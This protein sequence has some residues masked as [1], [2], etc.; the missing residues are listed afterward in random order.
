MR[1]IDGDMSENMISII[2]PVY[3]SRERLTECLESV[4]QQSYENKEVI[5]VDDCSTDGSLEICREYEKKYAFF[6]VYTKENE[7]VSAARNYGLSRAKG[8]LIQFVDS[9]DMLYPETCKILAE[10]IQRDESDLVICGYYNEKEKRKAVYGEY[11]FSDKSEFMKEFSGLFSQF[12]LHVPWNKLYRRCLIDEAAA[13]FPTDLSKGED[14]LFNLQVLGQAEKISVLNEA[15]YF[16]HNVSDSSLSFR[17]REDAM[18]IE[19]RLFQ[20]VKAFVG[21]YGDETDL[22]FLYQYYLTAVKN[23]FYALTGRSGFDRKTCQRCM[24]Q[25]V[26]MDSV[27]QLYAQA[28]GFGIKDRILLFLMRRKMTGVL[29]HYYKM[30]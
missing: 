7:G 13:E 23:K 2:I 3:N 14:L 8:E 18:Q 29:Y 24:A 11:I 26:Q 5:V 9:D 22:G 17:F 6:H 12:F 30:V 1:G 16:Y 20:A 21:R 15:L 4:A 10:R 27:K 28:G 25:W 19:E